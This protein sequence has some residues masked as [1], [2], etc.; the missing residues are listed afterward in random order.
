MSELDLKQP[1]RWPIIM[2]LGLVF[3]APY[4]I[5]K[6]LSPLVTQ[7]VE[8]GEDDQ[9]VQG[10]G[11]HYLATALHTFTAESDAELSIGQGDKIR[12]APK[13]KQPR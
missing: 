7:H 8:G 2:Y 11:E 12:L 6:L 1:V 10:L 13:H 4:I 3:A 5:W 9:W